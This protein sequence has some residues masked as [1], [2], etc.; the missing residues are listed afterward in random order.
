VDDR[1]FIDALC[2]VSPDW[3]PRREEIHENAYYTVDAAQLGRE[4]V[5]AVLAGKDEPWMRKGFGVIERG[6][7]IGT[8]RTQTVIVTGMFEAMQNHV[9]E[10]ADP[11]D[12]LDAW[13]GPRSQKAWADLI[14]GW[15]G[16]GIRTVA[17]WRAKAGR[18]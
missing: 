1:T 8:E 17:A 10:H 4:L 18:S 16:Q 14:E 7:G 11:P 5:E 15:T 12:L 6:L 13:L 3:Q 2:D 9:Y